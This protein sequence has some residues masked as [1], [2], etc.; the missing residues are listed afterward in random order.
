MSAV[1]Q[2]QSDFQRGQGTPDATTDRLLLRGEQSGPYPYW[3]SDRTARRGA[4]VGQTAPR[5][6]LTRLD[7]RPSMRLVEADFRP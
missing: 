2:L 1:A 3:V 7:E 5:R 6:G 4:N